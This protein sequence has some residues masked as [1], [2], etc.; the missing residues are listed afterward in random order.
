MV[1]YM[2]DAHQ[3]PLTA[4]PFPSPGLSQH[5]PSLACHPTEGK[6]LPRRRR[7]FVARLQGVQAV[8]SSFSITSP[9]LRLAAVLPKAPC[10]RVRLPA[11]FVAV[12]L[13]SPLPSPSAT[14]SQRC[15]VPTASHLY[16]PRQTPLTAWPG[17]D[18]NLGCG[19]SAVSKEKG[20]LIAPSFALSRR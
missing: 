18:S 4:K 9:S 1:L 8:G 12:S 16:S 15:T 7:F 20:Q 14:D 13:P 11:R 6:E 17:S 3:Q 2:H 10:P 5:G 19:F